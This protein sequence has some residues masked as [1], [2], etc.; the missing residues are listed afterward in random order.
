MRLLHV[1]D[2]HLAQ[3]EEQEYSL[4]VLREV[5]TKANDLEVDTLVIAGDLFDSMEDLEALRAR[6]RDIISTIR[7][8]VVYSPGNHE[9]LNNS[10]KKV[11][12]FDLGAVH[13]IC[14]VPFKLVTLGKETDS[15]EFLVIPYQSDYSG[16]RDWP[17]PPKKATKRVAVA[18]CVVTDMTY[19]MEDSLTKEEHGAAIG[20][21]L[22]T[23]FEVDYAALGHI[24]NRPDPK[25]LENAVLCYS[26]SARVWRRGE[27]GPRGGFLADLDDLESP[28][29]IPFTS[30][31]QYR[32]VEIP[33]NL[34]G[35]VDE[36]PR[37]DEW[38]TDDLIEL[39]LTGIIEDENIARNL[40]E[41]LRAEY[42]P[43]VRRLE[44]DR[45][46]VTVLSGISSEPVARKFI[47]AW[48][49]KNPALDSDELQS[50]LLA[51][52]IGLQTLKK[53]MERG[54]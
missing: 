13:P 36:I 50:W 2:L 6:F 18:H 43:A 45:E 12:Q 4:N 51:R 53:H 23:R 10:G 41:R 8:D 26:G 40:E 46:E 16:Y 5:V 15:V 25:L 24:H 54:R 52:Q 34:D 9:S 33:L 37:A 49:S 31:G 11:T 14:D 35:G 28:Q 30:A 3:G 38:Q 27:H 19:W 32:F 47:D 44:I 22:F 21:D 48:E 20:P 7:C 29:F 1:A 42:D 17:V 39:Q